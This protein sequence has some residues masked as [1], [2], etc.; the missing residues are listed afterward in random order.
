LHRSQRNVFAFSAREWSVGFELRGRIDCA[1]F[2]SLFC[3]VR[4]FEDKS[5]IFEWVL[6]DSVGFRL[7]IVSFWGPRS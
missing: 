7:K 3:S 2:S 1:L 4:V 6:W 5:W